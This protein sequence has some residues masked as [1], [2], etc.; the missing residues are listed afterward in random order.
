MCNPTV[1]HDLRNG[2]KTDIGTQSLGI[3]ELMDASEAT[4]SFLREFKKEVFEYID[5]S[6]SIH[7]NTCANARSVQAGATPKQDQPSRFEVFLGKLGIKAEGKAGVLAGAALGGVGFWVFSKVAP[8]VA[9]WLPALFG[10]GG[11]P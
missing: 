8:F 7:A 3:A 6:L 4:L 10:K 11:T 1:K 5:K 9:S 2:K